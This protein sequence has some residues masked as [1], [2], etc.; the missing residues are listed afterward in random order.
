MLL[1]RF[2]VLVALVAAASCSDPDDPPASP[3]HSDRSQLRNGLELILHE[4]HA[5]PEVFVSV[6]YHV[7]AADDVPGKSGLAHF[8]EHM[9][10]EGSQHVMPGEHF[11][12]LGVAG[13]PDANASTTFGRTNYYETLPA[14]QLETA[15][16]LESDR[17][18]YLLPALDQARVDNQRDVVRNERRQ[19]LEN[20]AFAAEDVAI[21]AALYPPGHPYHALVIGTHEDLAGETL[22]DVRGFFQR[23]YGPA[24]AT[25][26]IAGDIDITATKA[27]VDKWFASLP[28]SGARPAH[29]PV[30][31]PLLT[32]PVRQTITDPF[33]KLSRIHYVWPSAKAGSDDDVS[34]DVLAS[35]IG[36]RPTGR[37]WRVMAGINPA[38]QDIGAGQV[39]LADT[40]EFHVWIDLPPGA[41][42]GNVELGL[43]QALLHLATDQPPTDEEIAH[44]RA[45]QEVSTVVSLETLAGRAETMQ[46]YNHII[47][48]PDGYAWRRDRW[49]A[50]NPGR[51][52][53][54]AERTLREGRV[55]L[56]T[57]PAVTP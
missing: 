8:A 39:T 46:Y 44:A 25:L 16:W 34:L 15:L 50:A 54:L 57:L 40:S 11:R 49:N 17:M 55:E 19:R 5:L 18:S 13:N 30:A 45:A 1:S 24:N 48:T 37:L 12:V 47:G 31:V 21:A 36:R 35:V 56:I 7:G 52:R 33:S 28:G 23:W 20:S 41:N 6:W 42:V 43:R 32:Q 53:D 2:V 10:F 51:L 26:M 29:E 4:D 22:E 27:L 9:M 3:L 38:V 14:H